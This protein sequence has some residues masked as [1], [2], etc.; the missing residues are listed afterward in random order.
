[1][2]FSSGSLGFQWGLDNFPPNRATPTADPRLQR[3]MQNALDDMTQGP[4]PA[5][6]PGPSWTA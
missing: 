4:V 5:W 1:M 3:F 2:V 6:I